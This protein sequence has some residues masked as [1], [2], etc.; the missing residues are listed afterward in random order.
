[1]EEEIE[2]FLSVYFDNAHCEVQQDGYSKLTV[3]ARPNGAT[4]ETTFVEAVLEIVL[5]PTYP[6]AMLSVRL[7]RTSGLNDE[8]H[9]LHAAVMDFLKEQTPGDLILFQ[10]MECV[11]TCLDSANNGHCMICLESLL[12]EGC[13]HMDVI[14]LR[15]PCYHCFHVACLCHWAAV[16]VSAKQAKKA[17]NED[18]EDQRQLRALQGDLRSY[19]MQLEKLDSEIALLQQGVEE[20][21]RSLQD[22]EGGGVEEDTSN[23]EKLRSQLTALTA[24]TSKTPRGG[25]AGSKRRAQQLQEAHAIRC[26]IATIEDRI[27]NSAGHSAVGG[28]GGGVASD[29]K[30]SRREDGLDRDDSPQLSATQLQSRLRDMQSRQ[31]QCEG[32]R[33]KMLERWTH[34]IYIY[35]YKHT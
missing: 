3:V 20:V 30:E 31:R 9:S 13:S 24:A 32:R 27:R 29:R 10:L 15:T 11:M 19:T 17:E 22:V 12:P 23:L 2:A 16:Y 7:A 25:T 28:S 33:G 4:A 5:P 34:N 35:I 1:M 14:S 6:N 21:E 8:G 18:E 26:D